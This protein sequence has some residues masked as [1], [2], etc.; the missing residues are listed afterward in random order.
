MRRLALLLLL[1]CFRL[2]A[3]DNAAASL[4]S[5][6]REAGLDPEECYRVRDL[7]FSKQ[8]IR[9]Y[10]TDG[11]LIF[12]RSVD[13]HRYSAVFVT[14]TDGGDAEVLVFPPSRSERLS[15]ARAIGSPNLDEH[16]K[17]AAMIFTDDTYEA[18]MKQISGQVEPRKSQERGVLLEQ[19]WN[20]IVRNFISSFAVRLVADVTSG[21]PAEGFFYA[22]V[23]GEKLGNFDLLYD[24]LIPEQIVV[25]RVTSREGTTY[26]DTWTNFTARNPRQPRPTPPNE[27]Y[28]LSNY[29]ID[30]TLEPD[31]AMK[32]TTRVT[33]V[34][35]RSQIRVLPFG[36]SP[37]MRLTAASINGAPAEF[38]QRDALREN[39][40]HGGL[41][42]FLL[43]PPSPLETGK[44][45]ELEFENEGSVIR[46][47]GNDVYYVG[48]RENWYPSSPDKFTRFDV[49]F[50]YPKDL[51]L[52]VAGEAVSN[53]TEGEWNVSRRRTDASVRMLG[54][55]L[56]V[57]EHVSVSRDAYR[58]EVY[59]NKQAEPGLQIKPRPVIV[60]TP[61]GSAWDSIQKKI[62]DLTSTAAAAPA[63]NPAARLQQLASE[64]AGAF[65]FMASKFGSPTVRSLTVS[66]IPGFTGQGFPGLVYLPTLWY[67]S[68]DQRPGSTRDK[69]Q[70]DQNLQIMAAH[71]VAH[72]W[73]GNVL[74]PA[75][76]QD[77][78]LM[79]ALGNYSA[80]LYL[81]RQKGTKA[82][83][84]VL[85][86]YKTHLLATATEGR[87][88]D[89]M[90]PIAWG[91]RLESSQAPDAWRIIT[92]EKG[93]WIIHMLR[94]RMGDDR[95]FDA[96]SEL[97]RRY[98]YATLSTG[99][100][101][102]LMAQFMPSGDPDPKLEAFFESWVYGTGIPTLRMKY[103][104]K[105]KAPSVR[106][107]GT[108]G[109]SDVEDT[110]SAAVP[111]EIQ[112][113]TGKP[114]VRWVR[115]DSDP[116]SFSVSL[117][118]APLK[119]QLD[120]SDSVLAVKR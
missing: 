118:A 21:R 1:A 83:S 113:A 37:R 23:G 84:G 64:I 100:F 61:T 86:E 107:E 92:Y 71:E 29:R 8:D 104:S 4:A 26:F 11:Y 33:L 73:W 116:A 89:S 58:I 108:L 94:R 110:F 7:N 15:L 31:L 42:M 115:T 65:E 51:D 81:E 66:P 103:S 99:Q 88:M 17:A 77:E 13:G 40:I 57:Y 59:A 90:G 97:T 74:A 98:R 78:W 93:S 85:G 101:R 75:S 24:P 52:V 41:A 87:T 120:P 49:T 91:P 18:L 95:F 55:N 72:Q 76:S 44:S 22:A 54:F 27:A 70:Q 45:Y 117:R 60:T 43:L 35:L 10:L 28:R 19:E 63:P 82:L 39:L 112:P 9:I 56:G 62:A 47:A 48:S 69:T 102:A 46:S 32:V 79:E 67:L 106:V 36:L 6:L 114:I 16:L 68:P 38:F 34:P 14:E 96:L 50:R 3:A 53:T 2:P 20:S 5:R 119:V 105:G 80:L 12:G 30:A 111:V 25:G 109:Q